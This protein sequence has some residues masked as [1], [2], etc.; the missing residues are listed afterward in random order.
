MK[1][2]LSKQLVN[3]MNFLRRSTHQESRK[4]LP[5]HVD[6][7]VNFDRD[8]RAE[9]DAYMRPI[10]SNGRIRFNITYNLDLLE[11]N[12]KNLK[13]NS[14]K[15]MVVHEL[16]HVY[17]YLYDQKGFLTNPHKNSTFNSTVAKNMGTKYGSPVFRA[18]TLPDPSTRCAIK[19]C[20][21]KIAPA[22]LSNYWLYFC[23]DCGYYDAYVTDLRAKTPV[24]EKCGSH[25]LITK[26]M[27][28]QL[29]AKMDIAVE[30]NPKSFDT[31]KEMRGYIMREL[32]RNLPLKE[33]QEIDKFSRKKIKRKN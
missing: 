5:S 27:P 6:V 22:W 26:K 13:S 12:L 30:R 21:N 15:G 25:N 23:K 3:A 24:C 16:A 1:K 20:R 32:K 9:S 10:Y 8:I 11:A 29:A 2:K 17:D 7:N 33:R 4:M 14:I 31:D 28:I 19:A 18:A